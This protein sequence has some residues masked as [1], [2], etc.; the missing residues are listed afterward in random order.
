MLKRASRTAAA[1]TKR[2]PTAH[3]SRPSG[4]SPQLNDRMAG[5]TPNEITSASESNST[6]NSLVVPVIRATRPSS[7]S[8][9]IAN[10]DERRRRRELAAH[11]VDDA[12]VAAEHVRHREHARQQIDAAPGAA[13]RRHRCA[14]AATAEACAGAAEPT[15]R[16][17]GAPS[18]R[19]HECRAVRRWRRRRASVAS[20]VT[21]PTH[22]LARP[23]P[24][25]SRSAG[26]RRPSA[27][28]TSSRRTDRR[29][30]R[31][32]LP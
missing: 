29:P 17:F 24:A 20:T 7:M 13:R 31:R 21:P 19:D 1:A 16:V 6:P 8:S 30:A 26:G 23:R 15:E 28:R 9:T 22:L 27:I 14:G 32:R 18:L 25:A 10:A 2:K 5:A 4:S 12:G 11:R 3:P